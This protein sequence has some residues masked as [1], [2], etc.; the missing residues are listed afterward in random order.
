M[1]DDND[2]PLPSFRK[3][4]EQVRIA[5]RHVPAAEVRVPSVRNANARNLFVF[6]V[7]G[8]NLFNAGIASGNRSIIRR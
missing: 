3:P 2:S 8:V 7:E 5:C 6:Q 1:G 4:R